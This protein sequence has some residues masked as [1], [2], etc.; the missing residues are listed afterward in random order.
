[1]LYFLKSSN[2]LLFAYFSDAGQQLA[3]PDSPTPLSLCYTRLDA[4]NASSLQGMGSWVSSKGLHS[5]TG[6]SWKN[7]GRNRPKVFAIRTLFTPNQLV[8]A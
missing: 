7:I 4:F 2:P 3:E 6:T 8:I 1:M 5:Q